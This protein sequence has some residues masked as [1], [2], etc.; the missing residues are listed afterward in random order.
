MMVICIELRIPLFLIGKPGSSKS[1]AKTIVADAMQGNS[2]QS[3]FFKQFKQVQMVSFQCSPLSVAEGILGTFRQCAL[4]QKQKNLQKFVSV[5]VLDEVGLAEDSQKMPLKSLH[6]LLEEGYDSDNEEKDTHDTTGDKSYRK[7]AFIGISNWSLDPAKM[8]RG[9]LVQRDVPELYDL[10]ESARDICRADTKKEQQHVE[11]FIEPLAESYNDV[12]EAVVEKRR[13]F[14][15]LRDF[16]SLIKMLYGFCGKNNRNPTWLILKHCIK[17]NFGGYDET[18]VPV[19]KI[20]KEKLKSFLQVDIETPLPGDPDCSPAGLIEGC[21]RG[22]KFVDPVNVTEAAMV[23]NITHDSKEPTSDTRY[24][25]LLTENYGAL[26]V[27]Q[28]KISSIQNAVTIFGSNFPSD[29]EYTQICRNINRIKVCMESGNTVVLLNLENIYES[30]YDALNQYYVFFGGE[31]YVDLGLGSHR[32]KCRVHKNFRLV[33]IAEKETVYERFPIPLINRLEKHFLD[34]STLLSEKQ[35]EL[36][37]TLKKWINTFIG[38]KQRPTIQEGEVFMGYHEDT[39]AAIIIY[40]SQRKP[41]ISDILNEA[42]R[43]LLW[44]ATSDSILRCG[45]YLPQE[46]Q[47]IHKIYFKDQHHENLLEFLSNAGDRYIQVTTHSQLMTETDIQELS[48]GLELKRDQILPLSLQ[49]FETEQQFCR[50]IKYFFDGKDS[51][52]L[53]LIVQCENGNKNTNWIASAQYCVHDLMQHLDKHRTKKC[54]VVFIIHLPRI[55]IANFTGFQCGVWRSVHIDDVRNIDDGIPSIISLKGESIGNLLK[56]SLSQGNTQ[57]MASEKQ[58]TT[59]D[60]PTILNLCMYSALSVIRDPPGRITRIT[61]RLEILFQRV[62]Q[63]TVASGQENF[64]SGLVLHIA[65][66]VFEK[67]ENYIP[68][69]ANKWLVEESFRWDKIHRTGTFRKAVAHGIADRLSPIL[70]F[71]VSYFDT[72]NN[73]DFLLPKCE[74]SWKQKLMNKITN[75]ISATELKYQDMLS[76]TNMQINEIAIKGVGFKNSVFQANVPFSWLVYR[77]VESNIA[78]NKESNKGYWIVPQVIANSPLGKLLEQNVNR[79]EEDEYIQDYIQDFIQM[80]YYVTCDQEQKIV[81]DCILQCWKQKELKNDANI[82]DK[83]VSVHDVFITHARRLKNFSQIQNMWSFCCQNIELFKQKNPDFYLHSHAEMNLDVLGLYHLLENLNPSPYDDESD[84]SPDAS[85]PDT[86]KYFDFNHVKERLLWLRQ[87]N[88]FRPVVEQVIASINEDSDRKEIR[89]DGIRKIRYM[90]TRVIILKLSLEHI[91][92]YENYESTTCIG[93]W[94]VLGEDVDM[95]CPED[96]QKIHTFLENCI[97]K[98]ASDTFGDQRMCAI[99]EEDLNKTPKQLQCPS[100]VCETCCSNSV[101]WESNECPVCHVDHP[102]DSKLSEQQIEKYRTYRKNCNS[103]FMDVVLQLCFP[104]GNLPCER[105]LEMLMDIVKGD[106]KIDH[107]LEITSKEMHEI[108]MNLDANPIVKVFLLQQ[109]LR[110]NISMQNMAKYLQLPESIVDDRRQITLYML[111]IQCYEDT[112]HQSESN[113]QKQVR[114]KLIATQ[115]LTKSEDGNVNTEGP[116]SLLLHVAKLRYALSIAAKY[117]NARFVEKSHKNTDKLQKLLSATKSLCERHATDNP[118]KFLIKQLSKRFGLN[119]YM[120]ACCIPELG[121]LKDNLYFRNEEITCVDRFVV[122]GDEYIELLKK[123]ELSKFKEITEW[124]SKSTILNK[125][126]KKTVL[127]LAVFRQITLS[128]CNEELVATE[129]FSGVMKKTKEYLCQEQILHDQ[130]ELVNMLCQNELWKEDP[131]LKICGNIEK[132]Q[133]SSVA[134]LFHLYITLTFAD[135]NSLLLPL[136]KLMENPGMMQNSYLPTMPLDV[137]DELAASILQHN[138][139]ASKRETLSIYLCP[140]KHPYVIGN[141]GRPFIEYTCGVCRAKIGGKLHVAAEGNMQYTDIGSRSIGHILGKADE[142][143]LD[144]KTCRKMNRLQAAF[145]RFFTNGALYLGAIKNKE[146]TRQILK[147][148]V[149]NEEVSEYLWKHIEIDL[150]VLQRSMGGN[151]DSV[152][153]LLHKCCQLMM[154][155]RTTQAA[156]LEQMESREEWEFKFTEAILIETLKESDTIMKEVNNLTTKATEEDAIEKPSKIEDLHEHPAAWSYRSQ[157]DMDHFSLT[158]MTKI[159]PDMLVV[160]RGFVDQSHTLRFIRLIPSILTLQKIITQKFQRKIDRRDASTTKIRKMMDMFDDEEQ[161]ETLKKLLGDFFEAWKGLRK[162]LERF[163]FP[164]L[165]LVPKELCQKDITDDNLMNVLLPSARGP[166]VCTLCLLFFLFEKQNDFLQLYYTDKKLENRMAD[167]LISDITAAHL[168]SYHVER[169]ILPI[170]IA[171]SNY[172]FD[173]NSETS[174]EYNFQSIERQIIDRFLFTK[175]SIKMDIKQITLMTYRSESTNCNV[176]QNLRSS[177]PQVPLKRSLCKSICSE[178]RSYTDVCDSLDMLDISINFLTS[179]RGDPDRYFE[180]FMMNTLRMESSVSSQQAK[181]NC[182]C[183]HVQSLWITL[184]SLR[185]KYQASA[186]KEEAFSGIQQD[187]MIDLN[188]EQKQIIE[189]RTSEIPLE[190]IET[191]LEILFECI[192]LNI[193]MPEESEEDSRVDTSLYGTLY[194]YIDARAYNDDE[195]EPFPD[196]AMTYN[197]KLILSDENNQI[198]NC[199][200]IDTWVLLYGIYNKKSRR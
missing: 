10:I 29:Q 135:E 149:K 51:K 150:A 75:S 117:I 60:I 118:K 41:E 200:A 178:I 103:F 183:K 161:R 76:P 157:I 39:C 125:N 87:V 101:H 130:K 70:A 25:L 71:V 180:D 110:R 14:F 138:K 67:E 98:A 182:Q 19:L 22:D 142:R 5:V 53:L 144:A 188:D 95:T 36:E 162:Q 156:N 54:Q 45:S 30:L 191:F 123:I 8:N 196:W 136:K 47:S 131:H 100:V 126:Q 17:R 15:G 57:D 124:F 64:L 173:L 79:D 122:C 24:L 59:V 186:G 33:V 108:D 171:N 48:R 42:K 143:E 121:W 119:A 102:R 77:L 4:Y 34:I 198:R 74:L 159:P 134:L 93:L 32:V 37:K 169:D 26:S 78:A 85:D 166:G 90:W 111:F 170:V 16:Y 66:L 96:L 193:T 185:T 107:G 38:K 133:Q 176:L 1:L 69:K 52:D 27:L 73:L 120:K 40:L 46:E 92:S 81:Y 172:S 55:S 62:K 6:P 112:L 164:G 104:T 132:D 179:V 7:V 31:R 163:V 50:Q 72:N 68:H 145:L 9:I 167:V 187:L 116:V 148:E 88:L 165:S 189:E 192:M 63:E 127:A 199:Q 12:F 146:A 113:E 147:P 56:K 28:Q 168:I 21:L 139:D 99:C 89:N 91:F 65:S 195:N 44:C 184:A 114:E 151:M 97:T 140:N 158:F 152:L 18:E 3:D 129:K 177:V 154:M 86:R 141:C 13:E 137:A 61:E 43:V 181:S 80:C 20:F 155:D 82:L 194:G 84:V 175:S 11:K 35:Q 23:A 115:M 197:D 49:S 106:M 94:H 58:R 128:F 83:L 109:I 153:I 174:I 105:L 190:H 2:S 160:L